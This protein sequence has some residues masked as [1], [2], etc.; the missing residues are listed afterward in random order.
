MF[1]KLG[2]LDRRKLRGLE[3]RRPARPRRI[4]L[5]AGGPPA[6]RRAL[7][8]HRWLQLGLPLLGALFVLAFVADLV[9]ATRRGGGAELGADVPAEIRS[10][11]AGLHGPVYTAPSRLFRLVAPPGWMIFEGEECAPYDVVFRSPHDVSVSVMATRVAYNDLP[12]LY[13]DLERR[14]EEGG[15]HTDVKVLQ[16]QHRPATERVVQLLKSKVIAIDFVADHVA[17]H[18][19]LEIPTAYYDQYR[20]ALLELL[21]T[22]QPLP[23]PAAP[24]RPRGR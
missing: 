19:M 12:S 21:Q 2:K 8:A 9:V 5:P 20:P 4:R 13:D 22:Y 7:P 6:F 14:E 16:F 1:P 10:L 23:P 3:A 15:I 11:R 18:I 24:A 17:H